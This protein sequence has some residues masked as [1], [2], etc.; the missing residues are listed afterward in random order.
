MKMNPHEKEILYLKGFAKGKEWN[1]SLK[2]IH[3]AEMAHSKQ[4]RKSGEP[5]LSHPIRVA[6]ALISMKIHDDETISVAIL[7]DVLEDCPEW[8][9]QKLQDEYHIKSSIIEKVLKLTKQENQTNE[10]YYEEVRQQIS[11]ILV[12][13]ADR[14]HNVSTMSGA[15]DSEKIHS[16]IRETEQFVLPLCKFGSKMFPEYSDQLYTMKYHIQSIL[17]TIKNLYKEGKNEEIVA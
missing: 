13:I 15:F 8:T 16:Y 4:K 2:A 6:S 9:S 1:E 7:H 5:F 14:C 17:K 3:V 12:K 11:T 10:K